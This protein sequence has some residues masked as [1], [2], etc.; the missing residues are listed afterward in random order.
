MRKLA[1]YFGVQYDAAMYES[2]LQ[3]VETIIKRVDL[4]CK[5][6]LA[7]PS[8]FWMMI[9]KENLAMDANLKWLISAAIIM[10]IGLYTVIYLVLEQETQISKA[11]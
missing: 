6:K 11:L 8:T 4:A 2:W 1:K 7:L 9:F 5:F 3:L 10:P